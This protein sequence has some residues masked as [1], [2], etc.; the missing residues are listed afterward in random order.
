M[1][2]DSRISQS[3]ISP[4]RASMIDAERSMTAARSAGSRAAQKTRPFAAAW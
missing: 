1:L 4:W 2:P 3:M